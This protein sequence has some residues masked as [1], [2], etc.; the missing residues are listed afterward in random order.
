[1]ISVS[2]LLGRFPLIPSDH[3]SLIS[4]HKTSN[5]S[6]KTYLKKKHRDLSL[7]GVA[8]CG[9]YQ[10]INSTLKPCSCFLHNYAEIWFLKAGGIHSIL[11]SPSVN[12]TIQQPPYLFITLSLL[13][14]LVFLTRLPLQCY[15]KNKPKLRDGLYRHLSCLQ[16]HSD[17]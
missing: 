14:L 13:S 5:K 6:R 8:W 3:L 4:W 7:F 2:A 16:A 10:I 1:M 11:F 9:V 15:W 12:S 17:Y